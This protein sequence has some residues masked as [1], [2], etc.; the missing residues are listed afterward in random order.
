MANEK[1]WGA[2]VGE[3][4]AERERRDGHARVEVL[5]PP[6]RLARDPREEI[7]LVP[8]ER[9]KGEQRATADVCA[10]SKF[11][12]ASARQNTPT[13]TRARVCEKTY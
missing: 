9:A 4:A 8:R 12:F 5:H 2:Y 7:W 6:A 11:F 3:G 1:R 10:T 13:Q